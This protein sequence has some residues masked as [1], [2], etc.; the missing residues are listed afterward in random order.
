MDTSG[1]AMFFV[2]S[3]TT[4]GTIRSNRRQSSWMTK[5]SPRCD[6]IDVYGVF[7]PAGSSHKGSGK[8]QQLSIA[9]SNADA[10][11]KFLKS[12]ND[13]ILSVGGQIEG[14]KKMNTIRRG[15]KAAKK[16]KK[17]RKH[18]KKTKRKLEGREYIWKGGSQDCAQIIQNVFLGEDPDP[19]GAPSHLP[20]AFNVRL[21]K[22]VFPAFVNLAVLTSVDSKYGSVTKNCGWLVLPV[23]KL[24]C[25]VVPF[26]VVML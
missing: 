26:L 8:P 15:R 10:Y 13:A 24:A 3:F 16:T 17:N 22:T 4:D 1:R 25:F 23:K 14:G 20:Y 2:E 11:Y 21:A 12:M 18:A 6:R 5:T 19:P 9:F 7:A